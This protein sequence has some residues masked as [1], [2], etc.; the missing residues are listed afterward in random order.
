MAGTPKPLS[1]RTIAFLA[2]NGVEQIEL[3]SPWEAIEAAG[4]TP[5]LVSPQA[6]SITAMNA[7]WNHG[8]SFDVDVQVLAAQAKDY[9]GLVLPGG[10]LNADA[11]RGDVDAVAFVKAFFQQHKPVAAICHAP[12][13]LI[14]AGVA[15]ERELTSY[16]TLEADLK[17]AG[18]HWRDAEVVVDEAL[19]TSRNPGDLPAFNAALVEAFGESRR[20]GQEN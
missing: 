14:N 3:T 19:V 12:W 13:I 5:V 6:D 11:L 2:T 18:A 15:E 10:T 4:G 1:G 17:N 8:D 16:K 20:T 7:D 9:H